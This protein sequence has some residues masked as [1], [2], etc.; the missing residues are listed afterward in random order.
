MPESVIDLRSDTV[1]RPTAEMRRAMF[2]AEV[3]DDVY[4][5]DPTVNALE[6]RAAEVL[7]KEAALFVPTG[8]MGNTIAIKCLTRPGQ[9][10]ICEARGHLLN[11]ELSMTAWFSNCLIRSIHTPDGILT[12]PLIEKE[13]R[14]LGPH[15]A[16]TGCIEIEN[17]HNMAGGTVYPLEVIDE[18]CD[19][20]HGRG[21]AVHMDGARVFNAA[22]AASLP[23]SRICAQVDTVMCC[24]SKALGAPVGSMLAGP[25]SV[26]D[27]GRLYRKRLGGG[28]RQ[29][30]ILAAAGLIALERMPLRLQE[31]H[32]N[33]KL[34]ASG[35]AAIPGIRV[36]PET[37]AT[38]IV[39]FD[40]SATGKSSQE[41]SA[42]LKAR[43]VLINGINPTTM[44]AVTHY[45]VDRRGCETALAALAEVVAA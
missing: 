8:T 6:A 10:V 22:V 27:Q 34:V 33:A 38:N 13:I 40:I 43:G 11:Y 39:I 25:K 3:G 32:A 12:W 23:V 17:T 16:D 28:M 31:D 18:I 7:G 45:D 15:A 20:A 4:Q 19:R 1:T 29:A 5:E 21:I 30:G 14:P 44:R 2:E 36:E 26:I 35:L 41:I 42:A 37:P 9:E 24:L